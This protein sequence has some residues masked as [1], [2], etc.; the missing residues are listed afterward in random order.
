MQLDS[1]SAGNFIF[2]RQDIPQEGEGG[3]M[4]PA[5]ASA[6]VTFPMKYLVSP[7]QKELCWS[8]S[9]WAAAVHGAD[10][11]PQYYWKSVMGVGAASVLFFLILEAY[12]T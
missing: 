1:L 10:A 5:I 8:S 11:E 9:F 4:I 6:I 2:H 12:P 7:I 3:W